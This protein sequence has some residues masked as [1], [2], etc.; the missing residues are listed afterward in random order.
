[1]GHLPQTPEV[2]AG[3][4]T[5]EL[6]QVSP[7]PVA[8]P[9]QPLSA[10]KAPCPLYPVSRTLPRLV[11]ACVKDQASLLLGACCLNRRLQAGDGDAAVAG[12]ACA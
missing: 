4:L 1:M 3:L 9:P 12:T 8:R 11:V 5:C 7:L 10:P 2:S 6:G